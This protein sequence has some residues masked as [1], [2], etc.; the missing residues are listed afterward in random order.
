M[1]RTPSK[2]RRGRKRG[3]QRCYRVSGTAA[4]SDAWCRV[5]YSLGTRGVPFKRE[6]DTEAARKIH[7]HTHTHTHRERERERDLTLMMPMP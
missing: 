2:G 4:I 6:T 3:L 5:S 7:T 1:M